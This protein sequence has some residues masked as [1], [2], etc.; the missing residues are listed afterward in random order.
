MK[1]ILKF[2]FVFLL[3]YNMFPQ[4]GSIIYNIQIGVDLTEVPNDKVEFITQMVKNA[5]KQQFELAFNKFKSSFKIIE[6]LGSL[7]EYEA[8]MQNIASAAFTTSSDIYIDYERK[9]EVNKSKEG[10]L[11]ENSLDT[12]KWEISTESKKIENYICYKAIK[13]IPFTDRKGQ[14]KVKEVL[15]WFAPSLP[16]SYGPK[17]FYGLPGLILELIENRATYLATFI[18][19]KNQQINIDFPKGKTITKAVYEKGLKAQMGI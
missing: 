1:N 13:K 8:K 16:Y 19:L 9:I 14:S 7:T 6:K 4:S 3:S 18:N 15:A 12:N 17:N 11:V 10:V 5:Q 2:L